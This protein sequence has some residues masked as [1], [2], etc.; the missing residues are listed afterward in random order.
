M[1]SRFTDHYRN[2]RDRL[3]DGAMAADKRGDKKETDRIMRE[4]RKAEKAYDESYKKDEARW[5]E[6]R[7]PERKGR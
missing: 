5:S 3:L 7:W 2:E 6:S 4:V 1:F